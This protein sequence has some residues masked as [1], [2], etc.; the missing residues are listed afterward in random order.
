VRPSLAFAALLI[1]APA[2][3]DIPPI[4]DAGPTTLAVAGL[5]FT[6]QPVTVRY[7]PGYSKT[8]QTAV[9]TGCAEHHPNCR[10]AQAK[11]LI[12]MEVDS[13]NGEALNPRPGRLAMIREAFQHATGDVTIAFFR[14]GGGEK[15]TVAFAR[16]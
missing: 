11:N 12:G 2:I 8:F 5:D 1:A 3:A 4:P 10:L 7:P 13:L 16:R 9:L 6:I 14:R 15:L